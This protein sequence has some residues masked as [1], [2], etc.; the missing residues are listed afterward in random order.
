MAKTTDQKNTLQQLKADLKA[1]D[2]GRLY[3]FHG[4]ET[5]L[6]HHYQ[7][8]L[9]K[10]LVDELTESFNFHKLNN[11]TFS[12]EDFADAVEN[13]PMMA[14]HTFVWVDE[15]DIFKMD[16]GQ[17]TR[18]GE[19]LSDIPDYCTVLFTYETVQWKP[20]KR[21]KKYWDIIE[22]NSL[23]VEFARQEQRDLIPWVGRHFAAHKKQISTE[24]CAYLIEI[25]GGTMTALAGEIG[26]ICAY[27]GADQIKKS[28]IDAVT[29]PVMDAMVFQ[30]TDLMGRG[31]YNVAMQK[32]R[33]LLKMQEEPL[34]ILGAIGGHFRR[35][36]TARTLLDNGK[37]AG[38]LGKLYG[39]KE[40]PAKKTMESARRFSAAF[41]EKASVL[42]LETDYK[43]KSSFGDKERLLEILVME[44]AME[45][46]RG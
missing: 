7:E 10:Q 12:M 40:Y 11:E 35:I 30:M 4:E 21:L 45:A 23:I 15:V 33:Q 37:T 38:E 26:K 25:T 14:E 44:L 28:D 42:I 41:C 43:M 17:R 27:S 46:R 5:F 20:D 36:G 18:M 6:L 16:E 9:R 8:Q 34:A 19:I 29:E 13:L 31:E 39:L 3:I 32:L 1:K 2:P 22:S 24:L